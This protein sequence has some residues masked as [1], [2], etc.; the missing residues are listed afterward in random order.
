MPAIPEM[1]IHPRSMVSDD[2][3]PPVARMRIGL[4]GHRQPTREELLV[5]ASRA[6][7]VRFHRT[8]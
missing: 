6:R 4:P 3:K 2:W 8:D 7:L 1:N 5:A